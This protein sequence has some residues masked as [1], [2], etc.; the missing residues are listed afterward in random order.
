MMALF[1]GISDSIKSLL[2]NYRI[3]PICIVTR[4]YN[5]MIEVRDLKHNNV[6]LLDIEDFKKA[7]N[8]AM[9]PLEGLRFACNI[10]VR[11]RSQM[12]L[13]KRFFNAIINNLTEFKLYYDFR[14]KLAQIYYEEILTIWSYVNR[15][16]IR[17]KMTIDDKSVIIILLK[18]K[19]E[20]IFLSSDIRFID[21]DWL[22][23]NTLLHVA[24]KVY[25]IDKK[26]MILLD[27]NKKDD[28]KIEKQYI[29]YQGNDELFYQE[30]WIEDD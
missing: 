21:Y 26:E 20:I 25:K 11:H 28:I 13:E 22:N 8:I 30:R 12:K 15:W 19:E 18:D 1:Y 16:D 6:F 5:R 2:F 9:T 4:P 7:E 29:K 23:M 17:I 24:N 10:G 3:I 14:G 27:A